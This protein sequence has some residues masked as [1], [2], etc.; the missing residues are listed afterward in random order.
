MSLKFKNRHRLKSKE[1]RNIKNLILPKFSDVD[2][3]EKSVF[4][5]GDY[6]GI[7]L[8]LVDDVPCFMYVDDRLVFTVQGLNFFKPS[9]FFV[10][11][12]MG[13]VR[14]VTNG[15]D[16]MSPGIVDADE[17]IEVGDFV[18]ICD[19]KNLKPLAVG[20]ALVSGVDMKSGGSGKA[21]KNVHFVGDTIWNFVAKSL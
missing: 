19:E 3:D 1:I 18:W 9:S 12:D 21:I 6:E 8:V 17:K 20:F 16:V 11:V 15:A 2:I 7:R 10:V 14:F 4:E 5:V 13:A